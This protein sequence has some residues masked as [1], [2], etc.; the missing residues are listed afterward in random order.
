MSSDAFAPAG[1]YPA[2]DMGG[3]QGLADS[4]NPKRALAVWSSPYGTYYARQPRSN[5][6]LLVSLIGKGGGFCWGDRFQRR[7]F[8]RFISKHVDADT[9]VRFGDPDDIL[10]RALRGDAK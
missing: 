2:Y 5:Q 10:P 4:V 1:K 7:E 8:K 3:V 9:P 6:P